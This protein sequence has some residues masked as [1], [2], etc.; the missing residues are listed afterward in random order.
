LGADL[1]GTLEVSPLVTEAGDLP[2]QS[3]FI[4]V[5]VA[6]LHTDPGLELYGLSQLSA[7]LAAQVKD[8]RAIVDL[9][10]ILPFGAEPARTESMRLS[11]PAEKLALSL[12]TL[13]RNMPI[14]P[15]K[16]AVL[17]S[18]L[19]PT[20]VS[21]RTVTYFDYAVDGRLRLDAP[22]VDPVG[23]GTRVIKILDEILPPQVEL[24]VGRLPGDPE[25]LTSLTVA[26]ALADLTARTSPEVINLS[27][28][29]RDDVF[30]CR[31]CGRPTRVPA[32]LPTFFSLILRLAGNTVERTVTVM[33]AG[34]TG[35]VSGSRW[36]NQDVNSLLIAVAENRR[37]E[38]TRY[39]GAP[40]GPLADLYSAAA[41][42]GDDP[43][44]PGAVGAFVDGTHGT[45]FAAPFLA[46]ATLLGKLN[47]PPGAVPIGPSVRSVIRNARNL[48]D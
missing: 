12:R 21:H 26:N 10:H 34:N 7:R 4:G 11:P 8:G 45:S 32:F 24:V 15:L 40:E 27:V 6:K 22:R 14:G 31:E 48:S 36:L 30:K 5:G 23:H 43:D 17:D 2:L 16:V 9:N 38:R 39:S 46:A 18:G 29:P 20:F 35:Q 41:F 1:P 13:L 33:A 37:G 42:G 28:A 3:P 44:E 47:G 19:S 25:Q